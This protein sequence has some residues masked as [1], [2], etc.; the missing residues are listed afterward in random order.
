MNRYRYRYLR[1]SVWIW[2]TKMSEAQQVLHSRSADLAKALP[3]GRIEP[4]PMGRSLQK[5]LKKMCR[6]MCQQLVCLGKSWTCKHWKIQNNY[7]VI[8]LSFFC[9]FFWI[10]FVVLNLCWH[11]LCI[12]GSFFGHFFVIFLSFVCHVFV[13]WF[14]I[15]WSFLGFLCHKLH[16]MFSYR[17]CLLVKGQLV[18]LCCHLLQRI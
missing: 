6:F 1:S 7:F 16:V 2:S 17:F 18:L 15:C 14:V 10:R 12:F 4:E 3:M 8:S 5:N 11:F 9:H 13:I